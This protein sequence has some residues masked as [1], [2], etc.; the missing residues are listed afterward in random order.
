MLRRLKGEVRL[1]DQIVLSQHGFL[2]A[3]GVIQCELPGGETE[4]CLRYDAADPI[5][6]A[7]FRLGGGKKLG[8]IP[9][10][11]AVRSVWNID[12]HPL[13]GFRGGD[14]VIHIALHLLRFPD[15][16]GAGEFGFIQNAVGSMR[17]LLRDHL[18]PVP[19]QRHRM[20]RVKIL[21]R[22][23]AVGFAQSAE[24]L[25]LHEHDI[26]QLDGILPALRRIVCQIRPCIRVN[27]VGRNQKV[28]IGVVLIGRVRHAVHTQHFQH[29]VRIRLLLADGVIHNVCAVFRSCRV[30]DRAGQICAEAGGGDEQHHAQEE[31][32]DRAAVAAA[33]ALEVLR[34]HGALEAEEL[35]RQAAGADFLCL[36]LHVRRLPDGID[37]RDMN[38]PPRRN[39]S[40]DERR[41]KAHNCGDQQRKW[42]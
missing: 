23:Q 30:V 42:V 1:V 32:H 24:R 5:F 2:H 15:G 38:C 4:G 7:R 34:R 39:R 6:N 26:A 8:L 22:V 14:A 36:E 41:H 10:R 27:R 12:E 28:I 21:I 19:N 37:R 31:R 33:V 3:E 9:E 13:A 29:G 35:F 20:L 25:V 40:G 18:V 16:D 17:A 11:L